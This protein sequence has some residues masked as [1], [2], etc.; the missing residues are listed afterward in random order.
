M[1]NPYVFCVVNCCT[2]TAVG[3]PVN[4]VAG[5]CWASDDPIVLER[6]DLFSVDPPGPRFPLRTVAA[7][8]VVEEQ[9]QARRRG[10][11]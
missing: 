11:R 5:Q 2:D 8:P 4:L 10:R 7:P 6:G 1:P 3:D 9:P